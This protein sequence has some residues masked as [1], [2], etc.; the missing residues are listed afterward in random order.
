LEFHHPKKKKKEKE[1]KKKKEGVKPISGGIRS[2]V[3]TINK[4]TNTSGNEIICGRV[5]IGFCLLLNKT[6][7]TKESTK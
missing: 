5:T 1:K 2:V 7:E 4:Q 3:A 6:L